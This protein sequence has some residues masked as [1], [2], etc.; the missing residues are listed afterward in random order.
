MSYI[1]TSKGPHRRLSWTGAQWGYCDIYS[2]SMYIL[3]GIVQGDFL[4]NPYG[5][6]VGRHPPEYNDTGVWQFYVMTV[7]FLRLVAAYCRVALSCS[8]ASTG[9]ID[10]RF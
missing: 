6:G 4:C 3:I 5:L 10:G 2:L 9:S 1:C 7:W 8:C